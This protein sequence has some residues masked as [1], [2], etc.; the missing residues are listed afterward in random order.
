MEN[1]EIQISKIN[2]EQMIIDKILEILEIDDINFN[3]ENGKFIPS[4]KE[5]GADSLDKL[6]LIIYLED[7]FS[8]DIND[9]KTNTIKE[10]VEQ[11]ET[12][13]SI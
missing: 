13:L 11:I 1:N 4:L 2:V 10:I 12:H 8:M 3:N 5:L 6:E 9:E 7:Y